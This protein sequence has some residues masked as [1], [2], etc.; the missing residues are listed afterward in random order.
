M[1]F[2]IIYTKLNSH[3]SYEVEGYNQLVRY[4]TEHCSHEEAIKNA[5]NAI[6]SG[7]V[8][9]FTIIE[10]KQTVSIFTLN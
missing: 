5:D 6:F 3:D 8:H 9:C 10:T 1:K 7:G 4:L 2:K